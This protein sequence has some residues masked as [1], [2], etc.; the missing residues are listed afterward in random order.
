MIPDFFSLRPEWTGRIEEI[1]ERLGRVSA[2]EELTDRGL[3]LRR[4]NRIG[5][6]HSS[7]AI[8]GNRLTL[9]QVAGVAQGEPVYAPPRDVKEVEN[10]LA[11]YDALDELDPWSVPAFLRAHALLTAGLV[12]E[13]G[14][15]RTV[16]V[17]IVNADGEVIHTGSRAEKVPRLVAELLEWGSA[18]DDHPLVVSSAVHFL[19]EHIH[20]FRDGNGRI[21][22]LWQTLILSRWRPVFAWMPIETVIRQ[23]QAG[24]YLALQA[25]REPEIDAATFIDY[26][27][28]VITESLIT[29][30]AQAKAAAT[31]VGV[32][33]GANVGERAALLSLLRSDPTLSAAAIAARLGKSS[34]TIER[35]LAQLKAE[36]L[37]RREGA[38]KKGRW[39]VERK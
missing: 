27:F 32:S 13:A 26:M 9:A 35:H 8:E 10:A 15:F 11:A 36:G 30:E 31:D 5:A 39:V 19:I 34:R 18:S 12:K 38:P 2:I 25:S 3:Q 14:A 23:H 20:P 29:Y 16:E 6:V 37:L 24:Y 17:E 22:R 1:G 21:G 28:D 4:T 7:T 33:V